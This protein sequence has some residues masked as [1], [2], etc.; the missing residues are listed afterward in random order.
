VATAEGRF[1]EARSLFE[2]SLPVWREIGH[3]NGIADSL[4]GLGDVFRLVGEDAA[5]EQ[6]LWEG[7]EL[8]R[9]IG[10]RRRVAATLT[11]LAMLAKR[12]GD[13]DR[14]ERLFGE[15]LSLWSEMQRTHGIADVLRGLAEVDAARGRF[16]RAARLFGAAEGLREAIGAVIP[17][18]DRPSYEGAVDRVRAGLDGGAFDAAWHM[19]RVMS[20][21]QAVADALGEEPPAAERS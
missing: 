21:E 10:A 1:G 11:S 2:E 4:R 7:L 12:R 20:P 15:A 8:C 19:G 6:S 13:H 3:K 18:C 9:D 16:D 5:A 14:A 17:P